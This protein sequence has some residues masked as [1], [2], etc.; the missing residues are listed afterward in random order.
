MGGS[1][2]AGIVIQGSMEQEKHNKADSTYTRLLK[3]GCY[4]SMPLFCLR[5]TTEGHALKMF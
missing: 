1:G 3:T 2:A 4:H 5:P